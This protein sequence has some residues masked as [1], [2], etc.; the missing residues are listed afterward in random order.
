M[1]LDEDEYKATR[2]FFRRKRVDAEFEENRKKR[3]YNES[4][5]NF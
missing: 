4:S 3:R 2:E 5:S 1:E